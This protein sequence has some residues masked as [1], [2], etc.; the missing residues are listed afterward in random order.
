MN[1]NDRGTGNSRVAADAPRV[2]QHPAWRRD[3]FDRQADQFGRGA[4]SYFQD[5]G[6]QLA[7]LADPSPSERVVD[8]AAGN[9]AVSVPLA[10]SGAPVF[11]VD[12]SEPMLRQLPRLPGLSTV[13]ASAQAL[14]LR[15]R[16]ADLLTCGFGIAFFPHLPAALRELRRVLAPDGRL[17]LSWWMYETHTPHVEAWTI[18]AERSESFRHSWAHSR[19]LADPYALLPLLRDAGFSS[20]RIERLTVDWRP[21]T[22]NAVWERWT[23]SFSDVSPLT[24]DEIAA[25]RA[26]L[27]RVA[28]PFT[29]AAGELTYP[30]EAFAILA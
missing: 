15:D 5:F 2:H 20:P 25:Y 11:A 16:S 14:P 1:P 24:A 3:M 17:A 26:R 8:V 12:L 10:G 28:A 19:L 27:E 29:N 23:K 9:G 22:V 6:R 21:G 30:L 18:S 13:R 7:A 4:S